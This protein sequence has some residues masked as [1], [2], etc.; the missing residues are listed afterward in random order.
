MGGNDM[1]S[2]ICYLESPDTYPETHRVDLIKAFR[3]LKENLPRT[4]VNFVLLPHMETWIGPTVGPMCTIMRGIECSC[5]FSRNNHTELIRRSVK[6]WQQIERDVAE[7]PEFAD[8]DTFAIVIQP[9][10]ELSKYPIGPGTIA[11]QSFLSADCFH[12]SQKMNARSK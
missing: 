2:E 7:L 10:A 8:N 1:C 5:M 11:D 12:L 9:F 6:R 4:L 3:Y